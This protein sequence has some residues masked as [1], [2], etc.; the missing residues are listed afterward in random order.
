[1]R[2]HRSGLL[3][4]WSKPSRVQR[5]LWSWPGGAHRVW[6]WNLL[7]ARC[8]WPW[9]KQISPIFTAEDHLL[10]ENVGELLFISHLTQ[11]HQV[12]T[13]HL[14]FEGLGNVRYLQ[15]WN[16]TAP[17]QARGW[18]T[19]SSSLS[20]LQNLFPPEVHLS[21]F[22]HLAVHFLL[23]LVQISAF[24]KGSQLCFHPSTSVT[25]F[26]LCQRLSPGW[27]LVINEPIQQKQKLDRHLLCKT[28]G[29]CLAENRTKPALTSWGVIPKSLSA[30]DDS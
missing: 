5:T 30:Q 22:F 19:S 17:S 23:S 7:C 24:V 9:P 3:R 26:S 15:W 25:S 16:P 12:F 21:A 29:L 20:V 11:D 1:M 27:Q 4:S 18:I 8:L 10:L 6:K 2:N 13:K 14:L 28:S